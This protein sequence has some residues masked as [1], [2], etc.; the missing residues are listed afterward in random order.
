MLLE[1]QSDEDDELLIAAPD[2][3]ALLAKNDAGVDVANSMLLSC[4]DEEG[5]MSPAQISIERRDEPDGS[6]DS[7]LL[8][9]RNL[10]GSIANCRVSSKVNRAC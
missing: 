10:L 4:L 1:S 7:N 6:T 3:A 5:Y 2:S 8:E 9:T